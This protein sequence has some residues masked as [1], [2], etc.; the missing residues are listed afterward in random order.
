MRTNSHREDWISFRK[1]F[2]PCIFFGVLLAAI[3]FSAVVGSQP[4]SASSSCTSSQCSNALSRAHVICLSHGQL[5]GFQC[6]YQPESDDYF[7][8]CHDNYLEIDD[9]NNLTNPS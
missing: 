2:Q 1:R 4:V 7:F 3:V 5:A 8:I 6:P 9:C